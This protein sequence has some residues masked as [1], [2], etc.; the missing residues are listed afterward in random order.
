MR[1]LIALAF[2][3]AAMTGS[4]IAQ[5]QQSCRAGE[6]VPV[7]TFAP[8]T[9]LP[10]NLDN[11]QLVRIIRYARLCRVPKLDIVVYG[12]DIALAIARGRSIA[13]RL[14]SHHWPEDGALRPTQCVFRFQQCNSERGI[15]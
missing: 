2:I 1:A 7:I 11:E 12:N 14:E 5:D 15:A 4:A 6:F 13:L 9:G 10:G 8:S 3:A